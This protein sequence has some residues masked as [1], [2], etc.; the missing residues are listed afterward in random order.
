MEFTIYWETEIEVPKGKRSKCR[1][2]QGKHGVSFERSVKEGHWNVNFFKEDE[3]LGGG[4][5]VSHQ[6]KLHTHAQWG[7]QD[8]PLGLDLTN[9]RS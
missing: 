3:A 5:R 2:S 8:G 7:T 1:L 9:L 6:N 4:E